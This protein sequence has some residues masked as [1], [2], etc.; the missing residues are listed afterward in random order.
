MEVIPKHATGRRENAV[1]LPGDRKLFFVG[2]DGAQDG[3]CEDEAERFIR[4]LQLCG[5]PLTE[6]DLRVIG[7][8]AAHPVLSQIDP[9]KLRRGGSPVGKPGELAAA[10]TP[11]LEDTVAAYGPES[12]QAQ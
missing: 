6:L 9:K 11:D 5:V 2:K 8:G 3:E 1:D 7:A 12:T 10:P 4:K